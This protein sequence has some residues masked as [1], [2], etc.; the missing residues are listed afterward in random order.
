MVICCKI[1]IFDGKRPKI[2]EKRPGIARL[3]NAAV[4]GIQTQ[5]FVVEGE[6]GDHSN[7]TNFIQA[8]YVLIGTERDSFLTRIFNTRWVLDTR[9]SPDPGAGGGQ[10][11]KMRMEASRITDDRIFLALVLLQDA[12]TLPI[13]G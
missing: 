6:H 5:I 9:F 11:S 13:Q 1:I 3:Y 10:M 8:K 2:N 4:S 7:L 12:R